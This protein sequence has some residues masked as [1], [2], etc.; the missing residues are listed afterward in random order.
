M[1]INYRDRTSEINLALKI[2]TGLR[3]RQ[4]VEIPAYYGFVIAEMIDESFGPVSGAWRYED[5]KWKLDA[6]KLPQCEN[7]LLKLKGN[8]SP[9]ILDSLVR[10]QPAINRD[11]TEEADRFW[12]SCMLRNVELLEGIYKELNIDDVAVNVK[13]D[14]Q[15]TFSS[16]IPGEF[17]RRLEATKRWIT[18]GRGKNRDEVSRAWRAMRTLEATSKVPAEEIINTVLRL[19]TGEAFVSF[20]SVEQPFRL[21]LIMPEQ[22]TGPFPSKMG[23]D[24]TTELGLARPSASGYLSFKKKAFA[25]EL[26]KCLG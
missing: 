17:R 20:L 9:K 15:R 24:T 6:A 18:A 22:F 25:A 14:I 26:E 5:G 3:R 16:T 23:V 10:I 7:F 21:G 11:Q 2:P 12:L 1:S 4:P 8:V 13:V 19:T